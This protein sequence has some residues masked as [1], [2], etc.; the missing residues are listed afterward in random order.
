MFVI[1]TYI[2]IALKFKIL[3]SQFTV[4]SLMSNKMSRISSLFINLV[5]L[6]Q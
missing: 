5:R 3:S 1:D 4:H 2:M 6:L